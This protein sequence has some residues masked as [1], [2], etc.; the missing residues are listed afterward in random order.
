MSRAAAG[1]TGATMLI[2]LPVLAAAASSDSR[3][4]LPRGSLPRSCSSPSSG[5]RSGCMIPAAANFDA[6]AEVHDGSCAY[7]AR[8]CTNST[9]LGFHPAANVDDGS[10]R[11]RV[12]GCAHKLASN[13][14]SQATIDDGSCRHVRAPPPAVVARRRGCVSPLATN[15]DSQATE[16]GDCVYD[17]VGCMDPSAANFNPAATRP[18]GVCSPKVLGCMAP[19]ALNY[20]PRATHHDRAMCVH[21]GPAPREVRWGCLVP[22]A[23]NYDPLA[24]ASDDSCILPKAAE[25]RRVLLS[26][27]AAASRARPPRPASIPGCMDPAADNFRSDATVHVQATCVMRK[28]HGCTRFSAIN[29]NPRAILD[30]GSCRAPRHGCMS[31][32]A[33]GYDAAATQ[34]NASAC[35]AFPIRGCMDRTAA[36]FQPRAQLDDG[37]CK[38]RREASPTLV[39]AIR[40]CTR[41]G[42]LNFRPEAI[43]DDGSC[44]EAGCA[45]SH[46]SN[47][48]PGVHAHDMAQCIFK[49]HGCTDARAENFDALAA[50]EDGSCAFPGC[51]HMDAPNHNA[52]ANVDDGSCLPSRRASPRRRGGCRDSRALN[53]ELEA[54]FDDGSCRYAVRGCTDRSALNFVAQVTVDDGSCA[55]PGCTSSSAP[56]YEATAT[57]DDG[58]CH[59]LPAV[60]T[61]SPKSVAAC[62]AVKVVASSS[63]DEAVRTA[64]VACEQTIQPLRRADGARQLTYEGGRRLALCNHTILTTLLD[65]NVSITCGC[66]LSQAENYDSTATFQSDDTCIIRGCTNSDAVNYDEYAT[67]DDGSCTVHVV[68][69]T[70][71]SSDTYNPLA[72]ILD[73]SQCQFLVSGCTQSTATNYQSFAQVDDGSCVAG[74]SGCMDPVGSN[75]NPAATLHSTCTYGP[76]S[77]CTDSNATNY[78][79]YADADDGSCTY[80]T[81]GC[82]VQGVL[83]VVATNFNPSA[84]VHEDGSCIFIRVGCMDSTAFNFDAAATQTDDVNYACVAKVYG[85]T[86]P[87]AITYNSLANMLDSAQCQYATPGC[88]DSRAGNFNSNA[89]ADDGTCV[90]LGCTDTNAFNHD[91]T[92]TYDDGS[93]NLPPAGCTDSAAPN[94]YADAEIDDGSCVFS[95]CTDSDHPDFD[96]SATVSS[97]CRPSGCTNPDAGNYAVAAVVDDGSCRFPGCMDSTAINFDVNATYGDGTCS[98]PEYGCMDPLASNYWSWATATS[99]SEACSYSGCTDSRAPEFDATADFDDGSCNVPIAG[100][101]DSRAFDFNS[102]AEADDG[103]CH[104]VGCTRS[105]SPYYNSA[106]NVQDDGVCPPYVGCT[107]PLAD[108]YNESYTHDDGSCVVFGCTD[109]SLP[110][111]DPA[112]TTLDESCGVLSTGCTNSA[113][114]NYDP[115]HNAAGFCVFYGCMDASAVNFDASATVNALATCEFSVQGCTSSAARNYVSQATADD[116]SCEIRGCMNPLAT[117]FDSSATVPDGTCTPIV[118]GCTDSAADSY[119]PTANYADPA[120]PCVYTGC[121]DS[122]ADNFNVQANIDSGDC[123][124]PPPSPPPSPPPA[125]PNPP[126]NP[127][128]TPPTPP[129]PSL[130]PK[131]PPP[132]SPTII[133]YLPPS[134]PLPSPATPPPTPLPYSDGSVQSVALLDGSDATLDISATDQ[135]GGAVASLGDIDA[136]GVAD[137]VVGAATTDQG[138]RG[139]N[140]GAIHVLT[141][142]SSGAVLTSAKINLSTLNN[143]NEQTNRYS[144]FGSSV[145]SVGDLNEDGCPEIA[146]GANG[147]DGGGL[148]GTGA[149]YILFLQPRAGGDGCATGNDLAVL[150]YQ[151]ILPDGLAEY[152]AVGSSLAAPGDLNGDGIADLIAGAPG[153]TQA[154]TSTGK[155]FLLGLNA[156]GS[157]LSSTA[158][159]PSS[160]GLSLPAQ[161]KFG[162]AVAPQPAAAAG[163]RQ[164]ALQTVSNPV[165]AVGAP[166][167]EDGQGIVYF[168]TLTATSV[169]LPSVGSYASLVPP[170]ASSATGEFGKALAYAADYDGNGAV[171]LVV[172]APG[173]STETGEVYISYLA[174]SGTSAIRLTSI[175]PCSLFACSN[176]TNFGRAIT[177]LGALNAEDVVSDLAVGAGSDFPQTGM[178]A[179][180]VLFLEAVTPSPPPPSPPQLV[181]YGGGATASALSSGVDTSLDGVLIGAWIVLPILAFLMCAWGFYYFYYRG[182]RFNELYKS[183]YLLGPSESAISAAKHGRISRSLRIELRGSTDA[184]KARAVRATEPGGVLASKQSSS[185]AGLVSAAASLDPDVLLNVC[186]APN[187]PRSGSDLSANSA[188]RQEPVSPRSP[189]GTRIVD[190]SDARD[191]LLHGQ[192]EQPMPI[193][194][195]PNYAV[196]VPDQTQD[197]YAATAGPAAAAQRRSTG[198]YSIGGL[199]AVEEED[200]AGT[201]GVDDGNNSQATWISDSQQQL[202]LQPLLPG[203]VPHSPGRQST[204]PSPRDGSGFMLRI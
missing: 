50:G 13:Y 19:T 101:T 200:R 48:R 51:T 81:P 136:D 123:S 120:A 74:V 35:G 40:G 17:V 3:L 178:G 64:D 174:T 159:E 76:Y 60:A 150:S 168:L 138:T 34:H 194:Y 56:N 58:S 53:F 184:K 153:S 95:G 125:N 107:N 84:T 42:A 144:Y 141:L 82:M 164:R 196:N 39:F 10:C 71:P 55:R 192:E 160:F 8:G 105:L 49:R 197:V 188:R 154:A 110:G 16:Q 171:E 148:R 30:D 180:S 4:I 73:V 90:H 201:W 134:P 54:H 165:L 67:V 173:G 27:P 22:T 15:Y 65:L 104:I 149:L 18:S 85:C 11:P 45:D 57:V 109:S 100:C 96:P 70:I 52:S 5:C 145:T 116:G 155:V 23:A 97:G 9:Q 202:S 163:R 131:S 170:T 80:S 6:L 86:D 140:A 187:V 32:L 199:A 102:A 46:A 182:H 77:G 161:S 112:A 135:F 156:D 158:I 59:P 106:A 166:G 132:T 124:F 118:Y 37:S 88:T 68:G 177:S 115:V 121:T 151:R 12:F 167:F 1:G 143:E 119:E 183:N 98:F 127:P 25:T 117:N 2:S 130:P 176:T 36:N 91:P 94:Y 47:Y 99:A 28:V 89:T 72:T 66:M 114:E 128:P 7:A 189:G 195:T 203:V 44:R 146:V 185:K 29:Y 103:S 92:A 198:G 78:A 93:C 139:Y 41:R 43:E 179:V 162:A 62:E 111:Y 137:L 126:T 181:G 113:A 191:V 122:G 38:A 83:P 63:S 142:S 204:L 186:Y 133:A 21:R 61:P 33:T 193:G 129:P 175:E 31:P 75:Y 79:S 172:G 152:D 20:E 69:C 26:R 169:S 157:V 147:E 24:T 190:L 108:N 14:D 87:V